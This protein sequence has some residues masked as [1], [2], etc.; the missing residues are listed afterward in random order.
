MLQNIRDNSQGLIAKFIIGLIIITFALFGIDSLFGG[1]GQVNVASVNGEDIAVTE[2]DQSIQLERVRRIRIMG[3]NVDPA[4]LDENTL[5]GPA[6]EQLIQEKLLLQAAD[7]A[8]MG[9]SDSGLD[10]AIVAMPQFQ[11]EGRFSPT[12]YKNV[13]RSNGYSTAYFKRLMS[14]DMIVSQLTGGIGQ[15]VFITEKELQDVARIVGQKR[16]FRYLL[17]P[18]DK[19]TEEI[20]VSDEAVDSYYADNI[21]TFQ[22]ENS[23]KLEYIEVKTEDFY[24]D[25]DPSE[26][27]DAYNAELEGYQAQEE[28]RAAHIL[29]ELNDE[30][31]ESSALTLLGDIK[32]RL[33][34]GE[35]F[36]DLAKEFSADLASAQTGGD[37]GYTSGDTFPDVFE[38]ALLNLEL[39]QVSDSVKTDAGYHLIKATE[40]KS[41]DAPSFEERKPFILNKIQIAE[42]ETEFVKAVEDLRDLVF[43]SDG[44]AGPSAELGL[45]LSTS[46]LFGRSNAV[47]VLAER[48]VI[49][50]AFS[51]DVLEEG[52]NSE[53]IELAP[54]HFIVVNVSEH[55]PPRAKDLS[56]IKESIV[57]E[58]TRKASV[59][60]ILSLAE[61]AVVELQTGKTYEELGQNLGYEWFVEQAVARNAV[62]TNREVLAKAFE[63]TPTSTAVHHVEALSNGDVVIV[64]L[65]SVADGSLQELSDVERQ[66]LGAE[67][68]R[69]ATNQGLSRY[70]ELLRENAE[71]T[72]L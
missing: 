43:N 45:S 15:S 33:D 59:E 31:D 49:A 40:I 1:S 42:A 3:E 46:D 6:L 35:S 10:Q 48:Q 19:V 60:R 54:D 30:R 27:M 24:K 12:L 62:T 44:L 56:E 58:L 61:E 7:N 72:Y 52:N 34:A 20:V 53:V 11:E 51:T 22:T 8:K 41:A 28:R 50:A 14:R 66:S 25:V 5:R 9:V 32:A 68:D 26:V 4:M 2:L 29:I 71:I 55:Q 70:L 23:V 21:S 64:Q 63:L 47:G 39:N 18:N 69:N 37:L 57:A 36:S 17:I 16:S 38:Q 13:L 65:K 67:L